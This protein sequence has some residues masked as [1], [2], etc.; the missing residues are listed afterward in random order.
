MGDDHTRMVNLVK[1]ALL[2]F[3]D[4]P[5]TDAQSILIDQFLQGKTIEDAA[6]DSGYSQIHAKRVSA[7]IGE[8]IALEMGESKRINKSSWLPK[9]RDY[10]RQ[11]PE[12]DSV[13]GEGAIAHPS[14]PNL[15]FVGREKAIDSL[16]THINQGAKI[17]VIQAPGGVGKS[18]FAQKYLNSQGFELVLDLQMAKETENITP[19]ENVM[20]EWLK[21]DFGEEPDREFGVMLGRFKRQLQ[22]HKVGV[23]IDNLEPALDGQGRFIE[24]H[25]RYVELLRVL[26]DYSVQSVT[27]ITSREPLAECMGVINYRLPSLDEQAWQ[28][29][30]KLRD[31]DIDEITL[32]EMHKA[33]GGNALAMN[34]LCEPIQRDGGM[35]AYWQEHKVEAD[36]L[37]ELAVKNLI[38]EQ[39]N[40]L[41]E[42]YPE[43]YRLLYRLGCYRYQDVPRVPTEGLLCLVWD[44]PEAQRRRVIKSLRSRSLVEWYKGEYW[45]HPV[46]RAEAIVRLRDSEDWVNANRKAAEFWISLIENLYIKNYHE[47]IKKLE[48]FYHYTGIEFW[49]DAAKLLGMDSSNVTLLSRLR[50]FGYIKESINFINLLLNT[51]SLSNSSRGDLY[52][53]LADLYSIIGEVKEAITAYHQAIDFKIY[54]QPTFYVDVVGALAYLYMALGEYK[55][56]INLFESLISPAEALKEEG[57]QFLAYINACLSLSYHQIENPEQSL[58][59]LDN[60]IKF[61][62]C[63]EK[64]HRTWI[65]GYGLYS[66]GKAMTANNYLNKAEE[67]YTKLKFSQDRLFYLFQG[68]AA[69]GEA[70]L[71]REK[72]AFETALSHH[73]ESI[74]WLDK[75]GAKCDIAEAYYQLALTYQKMGDAEKSQ[76]AFQEAIRLFKKMEAP[77]QVEKVR[78]AIGKSDE[79]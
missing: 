63:L 18:R 12:S 13:E 61:Q 6:K 64:S 50:C 44:M 57:N 11:Q 14:I 36:L 49:E 23:L 46:I 22:T 59:Y 76:T 42:T 52:G 31:I 54:P 69:N 17:I 35:V 38:E 41:K 28:D 56:S 67:I 48:A 2:A 21:R 75:I 10:L 19:V 9:L 20:K 71:Y 55:Q 1:K 78:K 68:L 65:V 53:S 5:L 43:A 74:E 77:N 73:S 32:N 30:F 47:C 26:A 15:N 29:F 40:R 24:P 62:N 45:L 37:V 16:N 34:I 4:S 3:Q 66:L 79:V 72:G 27:L 58:I 70:Q 39:F 51:N 60:A 8:A 25:R 7:N 33:Y